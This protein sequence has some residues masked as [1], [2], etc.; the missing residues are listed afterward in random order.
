MNWIWYSSQNLIRKIGITHINNLWSAQPVGEKSYN[1]GQNFLG[2]S[3][4]QLDLFFIET[5]T[6][7]MTLYS[8]LDPAHASPNAVIKCSDACTLLNSPCGAEMR[9]GSLYNKPWQTL[10][11]KWPLRWLIID[12]EESNVWFWRVLRTIFW[13][14]PWIMNFLP[15]GRGASA[16]KV[17]TKQT[18]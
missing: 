14:W 17:D 16:I 2:I 11:L 12:I 4:L 18:D 8:Y 7:K 5:M 9:S 6:L 10:N 3:L 15:K 1:S 13:K